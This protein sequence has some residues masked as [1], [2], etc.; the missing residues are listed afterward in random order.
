V[1][2][3]KVWITPVVVFTNAFVQGGKPIKGV[4]TVNKKYLS[5]L[6]QR[7]ARS[8]SSLTAVWESRRALAERW[9][10]K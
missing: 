1:I 9:G 5:N 2:G 4:Y 8:N 7:Q 6:L 3:S 10:E